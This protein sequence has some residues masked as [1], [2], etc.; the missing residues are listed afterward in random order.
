MRNS[1]MVLS[2]TQI[3]DHVWDIHADI[4][5]NTIE[6]HIL[7]L[8]RKVD[9]EPYQKLIHTIPGRGYKFG[10]NITLQYQNKL[11]KNAIPLNDKTLIKLR[12]QSI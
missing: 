9:F 11:I 3:M 8:R 10:I 2:R 6:T 12:P 1:G 5:S 4:F 7:N